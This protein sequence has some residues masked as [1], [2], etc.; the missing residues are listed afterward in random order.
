MQG[1]MLKT[2]IRVCFHDRR[3]QYMEKDLMT[4]WR[5]QRPAERILEID[6]PLSYGVHD[7]LLD[8]NAINR[9]EFTW[10]PTK[11][12]GVFIRV[13][14]SIVVDIRKLYNCPTI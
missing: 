13:S 11:E 10:D 12:T 6:V 2:I 3:L 7:V 14:F 9:T 5:E 1:K 4:Q 8:G